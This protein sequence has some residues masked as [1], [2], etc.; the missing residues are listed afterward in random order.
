MKKVKI[1]L[2]GL[3]N[4]GRGVWM[5]LNSNKEEIMKRSGYEVEIAKIL[6]RD[7]NKKRSVEV[8]DEIIT[9]DFDE[10]LEDDSIKIVVEVMGG[11]EPS[12]GYMLRCMD[13]KKHI[14]T[15]NKMLIA[16]AGDELFE[17]ADEMGVMFQYEASVAGGIPI[18]KGINESLTANKIEKLY[19]IVNGTTNYILSK[20]ELE[21]A[22]FDDVLKEAQEKG[23]AEA[24][25]TSDIEAFDAQYKLAILAS[26]A[27]GS[28][29]DVDNIYREGIT[30]IEAVDM[31]YAKEFKMGI[32]LLAIAKENNGKIELRVHPT[33]I[34]KKHPLSNIYDSFNA[35]FIKGNAVGD[36]MFYGRGAG[37]LPTGSAVVGDI[38]TIVRNGVDAENSNPVVKNN[39][40][41]R[42]ILSMEDIES[43]YYVRATVVDEPGV[44]SK[45]T[46]ILGKN[47]V[48]LRS[49]IQKGDEENGNV[50]IVLVT[51]KTN[52]K[53]LN[54]SIK[55]IAELKSVYKIN[56]IIRIEDLE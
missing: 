10:I 43:K 51:H 2:L 25:P 35:V 36:L 21:G 28:K 17:K 54:N 38:V 47:N 45:I 31:K 26:L 23:Y 12:K 19:G 55:E 48:S 11:M 24:D 34:S 20:M 49:V 15:A 13:K 16:N 7:K 6:V 42:E 56:N 37:D 33:M 53:E 4:V 27:F 44:L 39:L 29:I 41:K 3:G 52:E 14:V 30:K 40:W 32:K 18:I 46:S 9:T 5:I 22:D 8:P 1:A 50:T